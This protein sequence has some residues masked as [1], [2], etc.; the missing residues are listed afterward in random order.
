MDRP[1]PPP[2]G[3]RDRGTETMVFRSIF[4]GLCTLAVGV[5]FLARRMGG[6]YGWDDWTMLIALVKIP[7]FQVACR[8]VF[9][10]GQGD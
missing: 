2:D 6:K 1:Q 5:R 4:V 3:D 10:E 9:L 7:P 8:F